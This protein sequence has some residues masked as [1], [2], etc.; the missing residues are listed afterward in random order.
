MT[1]QIR[2]SLSALMDNE[3][4]EL[5]LERVLRNSEDSG[6][7]G[8]WMRYHAVS[9]AMRGHRGE[10]HRHMDVSAQVRAAITQGVEEP[11][12]ERVTGTWHDVIRPAASFAVAAS[13]FASVLVGSQLYGLVG[14]GADGGAELATRASPIG[15]VNSLGGSAVNATYGAPAL[16]SGAR[17]SRADYNQMARQRLRQY[18]LPHAE[19]AAQNAPQRMMPY[20][21]LAAYRATE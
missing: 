7:R 6:L 2:E 10:S 18:M 19:Q 3:A 4:H 16:K 13:V 21:R 9:R 20:A 15:L 1:E 8:T 11:M 14:Q 17:T 5:E 12:S